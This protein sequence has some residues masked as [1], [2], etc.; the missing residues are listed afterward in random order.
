MLRGLVVPVVILFM[1]TACGGSPRT[2]GDPTEQ[3]VTAEA[4]IAATKAVRP[5]TAATEETSDTVTD[6]TASWTAEPTPE[7]RGDMIAFW[8][9]DD[10]VVDVYV[11]DPDT[12][13]ETNLTSDPYSHQ[14]RPV[15]SPDRTLVAF[16]SDRQDNWDIYH[17]PVGVPGVEPLPLTVSMNPEVFPQWSPDG[18][19][20]TCHT[21]L[22]GQF[23]ILRIEVATRV[24]TNLTA[25]TGDSSETH[26]LWLPDGEEI[27][28]ISD[29]NGGNDDYYLM[30]QDG[31][32]VRRLTDTPDAAEWDA[33][34]S[35]DGSQI[36]FVS[37]RD[38]DAEIYLMR[39]DGSDVRQLTT[40]KVGD[41]IPVWAPAGNLLLFVSNRDGD[42]E[43]YLLDVAC[44]GAADGCEDTAVNLTNNG[45]SD[46]LPVWSPDGSR[47]AFVSTR[48]GNED[49][50]LMM[51][52]GS[53]VVNLTASEAQ[54]WLGQWAPR[55]S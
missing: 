18:K 28:F 3:A 42:E 52:D 8:R 38:G 36:A 14:F 27:L 48:D 40:N 46:S 7:S 31:E 13:G 47:I 49:I 25:G 37:D 9:D 26:A 12:G 11:I 5:T 51:A 43:I 22:G 34:W 41:G 44:G 6:P 2:S 1:L 24:K 33:D 29:R 10:G 17:L 45:A 35:P 32:N 54:E 39:A 50:F 16:A 19:F 21:F 30:D 20:V 4:V 23:D 15:W 53:N 55:S